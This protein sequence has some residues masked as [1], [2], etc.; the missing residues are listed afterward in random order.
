MRV[1]DLIIEGKK[2]L[3]SH[4][5]KMLLASILNYDNLELLTHLDEI[6]SEEKISLF[7]DMIKAR[8]E[9]YP[10]QYIIGD[11][12][13][14]GNKF[15]VNENVLI[16]RFET[17]EL[18]EKT[19][20]KINELFG[21]KDLN[22]LDIG[23]G[24]GVIGITLKTKL[25]TSKVTCCDISPEALE[26]A[27]RNAENIGQEINFV[28]SDIFSNINGKFDVV[29]SNPPYIAKDEDIEEQVYKHEPHLALYAD[30]NGISFY[31][32]ILKEI[33]LH[34]TDNY[35]IAF[36]IGSTQ[37]SDLELLKNKY[38]PSAKFEC[39]RDLSDKDR[40][41]FIYQ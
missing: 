38:L 29:I 33:S 40:I 21:N 27:R 16:P 32:K 10:L 28:Q 34:L 35:L 3:H 24:S 30:N 4:E 17:E 37:K 41:I 25:P 12:D 1:E 18:V 2:H 7:N 19:L 14:H 5:V 23:T 26:V 11:V 22:I 9:N 39:H 15:I 31:E 36:E 6:V 8:K 13:F 20:I